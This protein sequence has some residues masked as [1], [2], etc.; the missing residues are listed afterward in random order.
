MVD[1]PLAG[2]AG[3]PLGS[4]GQDEEP[5]VSHDHVH[6]GIGERFGLVTDRLFVVGVVPPTNVPLT[7]VDQGTTPPV[8]TEAVI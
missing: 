2:D 1:P 8:S 3:I 7:P 5:T 6:I 4:R